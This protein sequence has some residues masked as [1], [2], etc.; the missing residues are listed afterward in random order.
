[1]AAGD[2]LLSWLLLRQAAVALDRLADGE[3]PER[4]RAFYRGKVATAKFFAQETL[5]LLAAQRAIATREDTVLMDLADTD[6]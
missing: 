1:M 2:V 6:W 5:P 3:L 4:R